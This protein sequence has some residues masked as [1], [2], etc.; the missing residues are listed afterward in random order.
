MEKKFV[1]YFLKLTDF[2][3][4]LKKLVDDLQLKQFISRAI[5]F[6]QFLEIVVEFTKKNRKDGG[7]Y[8]K[9]LNDISKRLLKNKKKL[10]VESLDAFI[11]LISDS[12][13]SF[14]ANVLNNETCLEI[15]GS[16]VLFSEVVKWIECNCSLFKEKAIREVRLIAKSI[17]HVDA[18][19]KK[20]LWGGISFF[21]WTNT[22]NV[23]GSKRVW[24]FSGDP[25]T[26]NYVKDAQTDNNG[27]GIDGADGY[28]GESGGNVL[29]KAETVQDGRLLKIYS[30][31][32]NGSNGQ[33]GGRIAQNFIIIFFI[34]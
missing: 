34:C 10:D 9:R 12:I 5:S 29:I 13:A 25:S 15:I 11:K 3:D 28:A 32:G 33:S 20:D 18:D 22:F 7:K 4:N 27:N 17:L 19:L 31:G 1:E 8:V 30:N 21:V 6:S 26:H 16:N 24:D 14:D 23:V 2:A